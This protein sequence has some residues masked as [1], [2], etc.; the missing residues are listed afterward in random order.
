[1]LVSD[2]L[3]ALNMF[4]FLKSEV[5]F[6]PDC[7]SN[8]TSNDKTKNRRLKFTKAFSEANE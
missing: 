2:V 4:Q 7:P 8:L 6:L 3:L 1:M 5:S